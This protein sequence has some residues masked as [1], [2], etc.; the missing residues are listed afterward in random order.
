[1]VLKQALQEIA[2]LHDRAIVHTEIKPSM[3]FLEYHHE[4]CKVIVDKVQLSDLEDACIL[5]SNH[6]LVGRLT[7]NESWRRP[8]AWAKGPLALPSDMSS[9]GLVRLYVMLK[10]AVLTYAPEELLDDEGG[11]LR[12]EIIILCRQV[13]YFADELGFTAFMEDLGNHPYRQVFQRLL[14]T[15]HD[16]FARGSHSIC[17]H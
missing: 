2:E 11:E 8:E 15:F 1:V 14:T 6:F 13:S 10:R 17:G 3:F 4:D 16:E 12:S 5:G 7:S 9:F